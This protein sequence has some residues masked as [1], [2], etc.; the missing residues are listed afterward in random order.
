M[1]KELL[2]T[3]RE[4]IYRLS[5]ITGHGPE[6]VRD[7]IKAQA[8]FVI[9]ELRNG[10]PVRLG[11]IGELHVISYSGN[12]GYDFST[13]QVRDK[14]EIKRIKFKVSKT[15]KRAINED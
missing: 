5:L 11:A 8:E 1:V 14:K 6:V 2:V 15:L 12:G 9:D 7:I 13:K 4:L 3:E 10:I